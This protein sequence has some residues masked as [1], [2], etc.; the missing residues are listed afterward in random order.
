LTESEI[1]TYLT[2][3]MRAAGYRGPDVFSRKAISLIAQA[4]DGL[5]R[6]INILADKSL[7]AA[8]ADGT[9]AVTEREV[10]A[11][12]RD[13]EFAVL[14]P[15]ARWQPFAAGAALLA[16]GLA[17]GVGM[18]RFGG[19]P[20]TPAAQPAPVATAPATPPPAAVPAAP[21][22]PPKEVPKEPEPAP[23]SEPAVP[24]LTQD[25]ARRIDGYPA[26]ANKLMRERIAATRQ[27][28]EQAPD[29][30]YS[31]ELFAT[32]NSDP[33]RMERFLIRAR[34]LVPLDEVYVIPAG[35]PRKY[36]IRVV[37]G[38]YSTRESAAEAQ[39]RLPPKYQQAFGMELRS[40]HELRGAI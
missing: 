17:I 5:S 10:R 2:F 38:A 31:I 26:G 19:H 35:T 12:I 30:H 4:S 29:E 39:G 34:D 16:A 11:A 9:H 32:D 14:R 23:P 7:L 40:F 33:A 15:R 8:F 22:E 27:L 3:R 25:Q 13:S 37:Y 36:R 28:L 21:P 24:L 6:R 1:A 20:E 18:Q